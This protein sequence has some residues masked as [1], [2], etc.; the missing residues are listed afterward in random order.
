M[1]ESPSTR[2]EGSRPLAHSRWLGSAL[3]VLTFLAVVSAPLAAGDDGRK[4]PALPTLQDKRPAVDKQLDEWDAREIEGLRAEAER[5]DAQAQFEI[6]F[7]YFSGDGLGQDFATAAEWWLKAAAQ[8][9]VAAQVNLAQMYENGVGVTRDSEEATRWFLR[10]AQEGDTTGQV[11]LGEAYQQ[12]LGVMQDLEEAVFWWRRA[13]EQGSAAAQNYLG[14]SYR[15]GTGVPRDFM[16][17]VA[18]Y[19]KA[20]RQGHP[21]AQTNLGF[22][23][24]FGEGVMQ[25]LPTAVELWR[26]AAEQGNVTAQYNLAVS[27]HNGEG[28]ISDL[29]EARKWAEVAV[30]NASG[31]S[32][33]KY[34]TLVETLTRKMTADDVAEARRR[35]QQQIESLRRQRSPRKL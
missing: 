19:E 21:T 13:A 8:D 24:R 2:F 10:A 9:H 14:E 18:W 22:M 35:A 30:S 17:A 25:D 32:K 16:Q 20:A 4:A 7:R 28:V 6:G 12:G 1:V 26:R 33:T 29:I 15:G 27:Y 34:S 31:D 11:R 3:F 23:Y 5:G